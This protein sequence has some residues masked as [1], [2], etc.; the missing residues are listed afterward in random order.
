MAAPARRR[1]A[2]R[3]RLRRCAVPDAVLVSL[4]AVRGRGPPTGAHPAGGEHR[5][6]GSG[7][8]GLDPSAD[9][10]PHRPRPQRPA[11]HP[12]RVVAPALLTL[13]P[14]AVD[15]PPA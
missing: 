2:A 12:R 9:R 5:A 10:P 3:E 14:T 7:H 11:D 15:T 4:D 13:Q 6:D 8:A 1:L